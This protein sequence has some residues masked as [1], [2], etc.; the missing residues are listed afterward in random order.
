MLV[1]I[2]T[3]C[4]SPEREQGDG[5]HP[6]RHLDLKAHPELASE[7][8]EA[9]E[10]P[11]LGNF[12]EAINRCSDFRTCGC[13]VPMSRDEV[14][15]VDIA[16]YA[17]KLTTSRDVCRKLSDQLC[18]LDG[19]DIAGRFSVEL[20]IVNATMP[21]RKK[22]NAVRLWLLGAESDAVHAFCAI[23][24][25]LAQQ[26]VSEY[27]LLAEQERARAGQRRFYIRLI[28]TLFILAWFGVS[29]GGAGWQVRF[30]VGLEAL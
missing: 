12:V 16:F 20:S 24:A 4:C 7:L 13:A 8:P 17:P 19:N 27:E 6:G 29:C 2:V 9:K 21:D 11:A 5:A 26:D 22:I 15:F 28:L 10:W 30:S 3:P 14:P 25:L 23:L 1:R 18:R